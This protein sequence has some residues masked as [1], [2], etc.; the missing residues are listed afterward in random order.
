MM[1]TAKAYDVTC[2]WCQAEKVEAINIA[3]RK[4][5]KENGKGNVE[6]IAEE[7]KYRIPKETVSFFPIL[8]IFI[9]AS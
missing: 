3:Y 8:F 6:D 2:K 4:R 9:I 7:D 5:Q 1:L